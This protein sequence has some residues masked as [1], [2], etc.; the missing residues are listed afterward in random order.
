MTNI[1]NVFNTKFMR[2]HF[3]IKFEE[4]LYLTARIRSKYEDKI[5]IIIEKLTSESPN[6][7]KNKF[8]ANKDDPMY[9]FQNIIRQYIPSLN[10]SEAIFLFVITEKTQ[11]IPVMTKL[12]KEI[13]EKYKNEDGFLYIG[14][15]IENTF[16]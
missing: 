7:S 13:Y 16:G 10:H 15:C 9:F 2:Q 12:I 14:Y 6:I 1:M 8:L 4:R 11:E 3:K 5:P